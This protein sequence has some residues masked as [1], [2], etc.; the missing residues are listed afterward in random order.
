[1]AA[2]KFVLLDPN[3][4]DPAGHYLTY[5]RS[6]S[7]A[8]LDCEMRVT[9]ITAQTFNPDYALKGVKVIPTFENN[10]FDEVWNTGD[11]WI[12]NN[13]NFLNNHFFQ[14]LF[15]LELTN[16]TNT[17]FL[18]PNVLQNQLFAISSW[19]KFLHDSS[20][21]IC[22]LRWN[23]AFMDY[24]TSRGA[25]EL[26]LDLYKYAVQSPDGKSDKIS[27]AT[28]SRRLALF[29]QS[30]IGKPV[31]LLPNPQLQSQLM[32]AF[33]QG[34][35]RSSTVVGYFG[36]FSRFR[37][38]H[39]LADIFDQLLAR[40]D[41]LS[42]RCHV[43]EIDSLEGES[44]LRIQGLY[45]Q[46]FCLLQGHLDEQLY[47][48]SLSTSSVL[49]MPYSP[50]F[51]GYGSSGIACEALSYGVPAVVTTNTT[52]KDEF[53]DAGAGH[54][55]VHQWDAKSFADGASVALGSLAELSAQSAR[56]AESFRNKVSPHRFVQELF[57][58]V[59]HR[60]TED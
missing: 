2:N 57:K 31:A 16:W 17:I 45:K 19:S 6:V 56:A 26:I 1:M 21:A 7:T 50:A 25:S 27:L 18:F 41:T 60:T 12:I 47:N 42:V 33:H 54:I 55:G 52:I 29:Y 5:A 15:T 43:G 30:V 8:A 4:I 36:G 14:T 24:N 53:E 46:R 13:F 23:N 39:L 51:Y 34:E 38:S 22:I 11:D 35:E 37:G 10:V 32:R 40:F 3:L 9:W 59:M 44:I 49:L 58:L 28:D 20:H 48:F